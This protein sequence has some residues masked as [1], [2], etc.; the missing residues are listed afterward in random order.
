MLLAIALY[1]SRK[2][3][4][5]GGNGFYGS[6][7]MGWNDDAQ[8]RIPYREVRSVVLKDGSE[9]NEFHKT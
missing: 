8:K 2:E 3:Y 9:V 1:G 6:L 4:N 5:S 7:F